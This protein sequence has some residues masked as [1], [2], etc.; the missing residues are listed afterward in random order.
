MQTWFDV[1]CETV[2]VADTSAMFTSLDSRVV[3]SGGW[4][5]VS[6]TEIPDDDA[7]VFLV[8]LTKHDVTTVLLT[9]LTGFTNTYDVVDDKPEVLT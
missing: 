4:V 8:T 2:R 1:G 9:G 5:V 6:L 3:P 7:S